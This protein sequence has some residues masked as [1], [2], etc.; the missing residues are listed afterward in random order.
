MPSRHDV[1]FIK[2]L[3]ASDYTD[4]QICLVTKMNQPYVNK[5]RH[6]RLRKDVTLRADESLTLNKEETTRLNTLNK[7]LSIP[8]LINSSTDEQDLIYM[9]V[10]KFIGITKEQ[11]FDLYFHLSIKQ[12]QKYWTKSDV[13]V[14]DFDSTLI[15]IPRRD[16]LDLVIDYLI[17]F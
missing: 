6:N 2:Q 7:L 16:Y 3:I 11:V 4:K 1:L 5:I 13:R 8:E 14:L 10:L 15:G 9:H 12:L 17:D